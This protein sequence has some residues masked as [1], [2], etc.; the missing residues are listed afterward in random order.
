MIENEAENLR[1]FTARSFTKPV[2]H[3][4]FGNPA[5]NRAIVLAQSALYAALFIPGLSDK[6]LGLHFDEIHWWGWVLA[7]M[8]AVA[9]LVGCEAYKLFVQC[10][11]ARREAEVEKQRPNLVRRTTAKQF[12]GTDADAD[13]DAGT[14]MI[15]VQVTG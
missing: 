10:Q 11:L 7:A 13:A 15:A 12:G 5:M 1:A 6:V 4:T 8:G 2:W 14:E 9:C 3:E